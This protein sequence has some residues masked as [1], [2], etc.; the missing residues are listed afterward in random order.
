[1]SS[2]FLSPLEV[3][4]WQQNCV[5]ERPWMKTPGGCWPETAV[6]QQ[7]TI[8]AAV[9]AVAASSSYLRS[10]KLRPVAVELLDYP[11][12]VISAAK[13]HFILD[14]HN[15]PEVEAVEGVAGLAVRVCAG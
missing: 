11:G 12:D 4:R 5:G 13:A 15:E 7:Q 9:T 10:L 2:P 6:I 3:W 1:V 8:Q 14:E